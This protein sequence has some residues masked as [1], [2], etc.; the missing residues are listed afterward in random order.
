L[1]RLL[2]VNG[3]TSGFVSDA[4]RLNRL[5][6]ALAEF[7][8]HPITGVGF[9]PP[10]AHDLYIELARSGGILATVLFLVFAVGATRS[11][12]ILSRRLAIVGAPWA[13][14]TA[15]LLLAVQHNALFE[16]FLYVPAGLIA[17]AAIMMAGERDDEA[18]ASSAE[19]PILVVNGRSMSSSVPE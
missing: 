4:E 16:R 3:D 17:G 12:I 5:D 7:S 2:A 6:D 14:G 9:A 13:A 8:A 18:R 19:T 11:G 1:Q 10:A 15:W